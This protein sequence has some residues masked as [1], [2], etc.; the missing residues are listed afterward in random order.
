MRAAIRPIPVAFVLPSARGCGA[1]KTMVAVA[2]NLAP[3]YFEATLILIEGVG[4]HLKAIPEKLPLQIIGRQ[5]VSR[6]LL[7]LIRMVHSLKPRVVVTTLFHLNLLMLMLKPFLPIRT[8]IVVRESNLPTH[9]IAGQKY[10]RLFKQLIRWFYP[11]ADAIICLGEGMQQDLA[12][13]YS[14]PSLLI[15][16]IPNPVDPDAIKAKIDGYS[17]PFTDHKRNILAVGS[18]TPQ[19]GFDLLIRA[20]RRVLNQHPE[21]HLTIYCRRPRNTRK[22]PV[23]KYL[24]RQGENTSP[25]S[26]ETS[27]GLPESSLPVQGRS[28]YPPPPG[29][30]RLVGS[31]SDRHCEQWR[32]G[33]R[34]EGVEGLMLHHFYR[35]MA[36]LGEVLADQE[37]A[38]RFSP[39]CNKDHLIE[40]N[41]FL[42]HRDL[43][44]RLDLIFFD[45]TSLYFEGQGDRP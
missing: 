28:T 27:R 20:F 7:Q 32:T 29:A 12:R 35:A 21:A 15:A 9:A 19:K 37:G 10:E 11:R 36:F 2:G 26:K 13:H 33:Y 8:K 22:S 43:F 18:L 31:G 40:E 44:S 25:L 5:R 41:L 23:R 4:P 45:T 30:K 34:I 38:A 39:R 6:S 16:D 42:A 1:E 3:E 14:I 24:V 17:N